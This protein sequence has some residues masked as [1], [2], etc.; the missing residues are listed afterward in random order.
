MKTDQSPAEITPE[1]TISQ[2]TAAD[3]QAAELLASIGLSLSKHEDETLR[4]VCQ[5]RQWSEVEVLNWVKK[6]RFTTKGGPDENEMERPPGGA[7]SPEEWGR[8]LEKGYINPHLELLE[9]LN[10]SFA[11][12]H[13]IH[14]NQYLWL[15]N[16]QWHFDKFE[17]ALRMYYRFEKEKL[18]P[19]LAR[20]MNS[21][22]GNINHGIIRK[23]Q[24]S[25]SIIKRDQDRLT[26]LMKTIRRKGNNFENPEGACTTLRIQS[27]NFEIL[28]SSLYKQFK[29]ESEQFIP[30]VKKEIKAQK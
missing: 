16:M 13:K 5:Q 18:F 20:L 9:E 22:R 21:K 4:S 7:A 1:A 3:E 23:L 11:R 25:F 28:F 12:V 2:I 26:R 8:Y 15:K 10:K 19:L 27:K 6:H 30:G 29:V 17:E 24:K 14:G